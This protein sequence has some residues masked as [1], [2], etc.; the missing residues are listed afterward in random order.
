ME[1]YKIKLD[2]FKSS[3]KYYASG[4]YSTKQKAFYKVFEE[5]ES[6][7]TMNA[8]PGVSGNEFIIHIDSEE[9]PCGY[10]HLIL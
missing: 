9:H 3:G 10:P 5:V 7:K 8:L 2:Y 6:M 1:E 4:E